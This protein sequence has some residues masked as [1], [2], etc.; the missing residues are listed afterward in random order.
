MSKSI[1]Q[2]VLILTLICASSILFA[3]S[4]ED[5]NDVEIDDQEQ[6]NFFNGLEEERFKTNLSGRENS[7]IGLIDYSRDYKSK[8]SNYNLFDGDRNFQQFQYNN[9]EESG[10][11]DNSKQQGIIIGSSGNS[12]NSAQN[13]IKDLNFEKPQI[14]NPYSQNPGVKTPRNIDAV[15]DNGDDPN[16]VPLDGGVL[17]L[18][19]AAITFGYRKVKSKQ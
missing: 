7:K 11:K 2:Y 19:L 4:E 3:Q 6:V 5:E 12:P 16:D 8:S 13:P 17:V 14:N 15:P 9:Q 1:L 18:G 10:N